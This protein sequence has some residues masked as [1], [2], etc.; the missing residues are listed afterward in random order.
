MYLLSLLPYFLVIPFSALVPPIVPSPLLDTPFSC[1]PYLLSP[2]PHFPSLLSLPPTH[3]VARKWALSNEFMGVGPLSVDGHHMHLV[4][5]WPWIQ[6]WLI[7][8]CCHANRLKS[9]WGNNGV[10]RRWHA[11]TVPWIGVYAAS[12]LPPPVAIITLP[13]PCWRTCAQWKWCHSH[14]CPSAE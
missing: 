8:V 9:K 4:R 10:T 6:K 7:Q 13:L 3:F 5:T 1:P 11:S 12:S 2:P 14:L